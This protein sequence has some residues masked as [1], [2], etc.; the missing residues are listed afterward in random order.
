MRAAHRVEDIRAAEAKLIEELQR[1]GR[2]IDV[3]MERA[4]T[5]LATASIA[6]LGR[7]YGARV[8]LLVGSGDNGGDALYA[9][10]QL[11]RRGARVDALLLVR[12]RAH[13]RGLAA[14]RVA[15]GRVSDDPEVLDRADLVLDGI[16]GIGASGGLRPD[17]AALADRAAAGPGLVVAV[18]LPSG[19]AADTGEVPGPA[20][21]ADATVTFGTWKP[22]L[23]ADPAA[24]LAGAATLVDIGLG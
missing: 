1:A 10:A 22:A 9:G 24:G 20:T 4:S 3:L 18:D 23:L 17:A 11:A 15:G 19:V 21:R 6:L 14:L 2:G 7:V 13:P 16:V 12:D 5:G 8:V